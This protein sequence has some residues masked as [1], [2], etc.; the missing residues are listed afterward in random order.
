LLEVQCKHRITLKLFGQYYYSFNR[1][2]AIFTGMNVIDFVSNTVHQ[3][4]GQPP[5]LV[6][7]ADETGIVI[8]IMNPINA[9]LLIGRDGR[10]MKSIQIVASAIGY[11]GKH[12]VHVYVEEDH[13]S[14]R[15]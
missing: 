5:E 11:E 6:H 14:S 15:N 2:C 12:R 10:T 7:E 4:T 13:P 9:P 8:K 1:G 3:L